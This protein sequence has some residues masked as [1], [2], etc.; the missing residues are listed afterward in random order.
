MPKHFIISFER[1]GG[2]TGIPVKCSID[3]S[4]LPAEEFKKFSEMIDKID[5]KN[6]SGNKNFSAGYPDQVDYKLDIRIEGDKY[7]FEFREQSMPTEIK[8][9]IK[10]L[11][12]WAR[13][14]N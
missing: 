11:E 13:K 2:F 6:L 9:L 5:F 3:S 7:S 1:S 4:I 14:R 8:P 12:L 10:G